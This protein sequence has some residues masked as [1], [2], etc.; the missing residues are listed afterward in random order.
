MT[1]VS[2][3]SYSPNASRES[4]GGCTVRECASIVRCMSATAIATMPVSAIPKA[5]APSRAFVRSWLILISVLILALGAVEDVYGNTDGGDVYGSDA[6]QY[7][8]ISRA[9]SRHD[10]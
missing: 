6:V 10:W 4:I 5:W 9:I 8:D 3:L 2:Y 7:L 1:V